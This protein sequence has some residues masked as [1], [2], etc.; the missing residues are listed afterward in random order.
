MFASGLPEGL[1]GVSP[2][3]TTPL[4]KQG[5]RTAPTAPMPPRDTPSAEPMSEPEL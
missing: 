4:I 2:C 5:R 1:G 3:S